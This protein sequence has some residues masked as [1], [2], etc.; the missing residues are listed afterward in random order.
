MTDEKNQ[1]KENTHHE[2]IDKTDITNDYQEK[3]ILED[4]E[5]I[6]G[7][8]FELWKKIKK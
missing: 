5:F 8:C 6:E 1:D 7:E 4:E 2:I 3:D